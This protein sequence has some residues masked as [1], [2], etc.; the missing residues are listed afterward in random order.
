MMLPDCVLNAHLAHLY[1]Q[2]ECRWQTTRES[3]AAKGIKGAVQTLS[4]KKQK[5]GQIRRM[6]MC[7]EEMEA[8]RGAVQL[9]D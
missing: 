8:H 1:K 3:V 2:A 7:V 6:R 5:V 4:W 9:A